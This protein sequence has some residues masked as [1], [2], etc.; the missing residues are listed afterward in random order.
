MSGHSGDRYGPYVFKYR[1]TSP[2]SQTN[3]PPR[4]P[5]AQEKDAGGG[6]ETTKLDTTRGA[7]S[8]S[9][10]RRSSSAVTGAAP[11]SFR[12]NFG[13]KILARR[14]RD[15]SPRLRESATRTSE[16]SGP[17]MRES[18]P[19]S[20]THNADFHGRLCEQRPPGIAPTCN[21]R[22]RAAGRGLEWLAYKQC[23]MFY[24]T[25]RADSDCDTLVQPLS[26]AASTLV[27]QEPE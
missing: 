13:M 1:K 17:M 22:W 7:L 19:C 8:S 26:A 16:E 10:L 25:H 14:F 24:E 21:G 18:R 23:G 9:R 12:V 2:A 15:S 11:P 4:S 6:A 3:D 20:F 27:V 5:S